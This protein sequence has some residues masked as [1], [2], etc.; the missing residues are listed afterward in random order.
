MNLD[1]AR[2]LIVSGELLSEERC[3]DFQRQW[4]DMGRTA[5]QGDDFV[6]WLA[7]QRQLSDFQAQAVRAGIAGPYLLGPYRVTGRITAGRLGD[8]YHAEHVEFHQPVSLKV[9]PAT[10]AQDPERLARL[11]REARVS[12]QVDHPHVVKTYQVGKAGPVTFIALEAL[13]GET[14]EQRLKREGRLSVVEA[15]RLIQQA[16][17]GL[18][19]MHS[20]EIVHRDICPANLWVT[21]EGVVKVM[22]F[23]A[24]RDAMSFVDSL[25]GEEGV[26]LTINSA[27]GN[28]LGTYD[29]MCAEQA[30][31][32]HSA[33]AASDLYSLGCVFYHCLTGQ[34]PF[35]DK[36]PVRQML[37][38]AK[39]EPRPLA[40][41]IPDVPQLVQDIMNYLL[42]KNPDER[43]DSG[44]E[45]AAD[46]GAII[47]LAALPPT[48]VAAPEFLGWLQT[49]DNEAS[50]TTETPPDPEMQTFFTF[51]SE[52][53]DEDEEE[54]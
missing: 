35:P 23:S 4:L 52:Y 39:E 11:G 17:R 1:A 33:D 54:T 30:E 7:E 32:P 31:N 9:F 42:A 43:Y 46:L 51:L 14:L 21:D 22:E 6:Q 44:E 53:R 38:H 27:S 12:L 8:V 50:A 24:A 15:C 45:V 3:R 49:V 36:N 40:D 16:A 18:G 47:P 41:F 26:E 37:R 25:D 28:L 19:S 48:P 10:L 5:D 34:V 2:G 20:Q 29:Y 13:S